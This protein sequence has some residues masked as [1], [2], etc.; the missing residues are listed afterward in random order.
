MFWTFVLRSLCQDWIK[1]IAHVNACFFSDS[2]FNVSIDG[3]SHQGHLSPSSPPPSSAWICHVPH[4]NIQRTSFHC[5]SS[6]QLQSQH[7]GQHH[8]NSNSRIAISC[9]ILKLFYK[10]FAQK[11]YLV[12]NM[13]GTPV[14]ILQGHFQGTWHL[15]TLGFLWCHSIGKMDSELSIAYLKGLIVFKSMFTKKKWTIFACMYFFTL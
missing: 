11:F 14:T 8:H 13:H 12:R 5:W 10:H 9:L 2:K 1:E 15:I 3:S 6:H 7:H 4:L